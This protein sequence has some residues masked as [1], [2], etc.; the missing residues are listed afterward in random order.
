MLLIGRCKKT[1][2]TFVNFTIII[3]K[4]PHHFV[5][6]ILKYFVECFGSGVIRGFGYFY[7]SFIL[8]R[9]LLLGVRSYP[10]PSHSLRFFFSQ[11]HHHAC[12]G[13]CVCVL[14][15]LAKATIK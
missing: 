12:V 3:D 4:Y 7:G 6:F 8:F 2:V 15:P 1:I 14:I 9:F 5:H 10:T 11:T 13:V